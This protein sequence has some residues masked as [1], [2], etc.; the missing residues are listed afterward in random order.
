MRHDKCVVQFA[1][2]RLAVASPN[3]RES[4]KMFA[5]EIRNP[6]KFGLWNPE[7][8]ALEYDIQLMESGIPVTIVIQIPSSTDK[9]WNT[10]PGIQNPRSGIHKSKP[11]LDTLTTGELQ[12]K[13]QNVFYTF[14]NLICALPSTSR[15]INTPTLFHTFLNGKD[16]CHKESFNFSYYFFNSILTSP[17]SIQKGFFSSS[18]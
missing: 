14:S 5:C 4:G 9:E 10:V 7:S 15:Q 11:V 16:P 2:P 13:K 12:L 18:F 3:V 1:S 17:A 8:W 6:G